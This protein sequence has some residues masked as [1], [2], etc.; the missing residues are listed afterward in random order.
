[1]TFDVGMA[2]DFEYTGRVN[3]NSLEE[4]KLFMEFNKTDVIIYRPT[5]E[6]GN[7]KIVVCDERVSK[8]RNGNRSTDKSSKELR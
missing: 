8:G 6:G 3:I 7:Y 1:M 4:L 2:S 5:I